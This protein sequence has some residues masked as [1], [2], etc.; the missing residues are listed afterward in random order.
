MQ[1]CGVKLRGQHSSKSKNMM[2]LE[3]TKSLQS[4]PLSSLLK[5]CC[6]FTAE[7]ILC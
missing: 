7:G 3:S 2:A 1:V 5:E 6:N 4:I